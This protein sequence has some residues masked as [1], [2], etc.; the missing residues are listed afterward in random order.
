MLAPPKSSPA[1]RTPAK[2]ITRENM[3]TKK[4]PPNPKRESENTRL[5]ETLAP[6]STAVRRLAL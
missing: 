5:W 4:R 6:D 3:S 2:T 1:N